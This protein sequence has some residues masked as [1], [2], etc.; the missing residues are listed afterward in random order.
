M[1]VLICTGKNDTHGHALIWALKL[2]GVRCDLWSMAEFPDRQLASIRISNSKPNSISI[3][4][5]SSSERYT[6]IWMRRIVSPETISD[7]LARTDVKMALLQSR[8][9][10]E[11]LRTLV[12]PGSIWINPQNTQMHANSKPYQLMA[13]K[14]VGFIIPETLSSNDPDAVRRFFR[15][16]KGNVIYK[17]FAPAFW[18]NRE[19]HRVA[20]LFTS[21]LNEAL[22]RQDDVAF[23]SCPGIYQQQ[24]EKKA[25]LR[26]TFFGAAYQAARIYSQQAPAG[27]LD[28]RSDMKGEAPIEEAVLD[29]SIVDRCREFLS[30]LGLLH[31]SFDLI[32]KPDGS[33]VFLEINEMGQFLWLEERIPEMQLL[34]MFAAFSL[35]P[36]SDFVFDSKRWPT[37]SF[38]EFIASEAYALLSKELAD[39][40]A[41][42]S[43]K[44]NAFFYPE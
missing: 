37:I 20:G 34:A 2:L 12:S 18:E 31:G 40:Y 35:E 28:F 27:K 33:I 16:H 7:Q 1:S 8:R 5:V 42:E 39:Y 26:V 13:A 22:L 21:A 44:N 19:A 11:G 41:S 29:S 30:E 23:T 17:P 6:S 38:H 9:F 25:E 43:P 32:E 36:S 3:P 24:I 10:A 14:K 15:E 4:G